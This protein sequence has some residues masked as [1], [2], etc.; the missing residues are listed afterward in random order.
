MGMSDASLPSG[1]VPT[2]ETKLSVWLTALALSVVGGM[3]WFV[4]SGPAIARKNP[5]RRRKLGR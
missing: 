2:A 3:L 5:R 1:D 4:T